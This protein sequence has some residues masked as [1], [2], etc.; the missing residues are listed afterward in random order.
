MRNGILP[1]NSEKKSR[2]T[3]ILQQTLPLFCSYNRKHPIRRYCTFG[4][5]CFGTN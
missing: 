1:E 4:V 3:D 5:A 2:W